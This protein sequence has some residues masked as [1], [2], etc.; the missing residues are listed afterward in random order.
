MGFRSRGGLSPAI[1][2][3]LVAGSLLVILVLSVLA[4]SSGG[5]PSLASRTQQVASQLRCPICQGESVYDSPSSLATAMRS[6]IRRQLAAG[7]S[8]NQVKSYFVSRYGAWIL[9]APPDSGIGRLAWLAPP[10]AVLGGLVSLAF[11]LRRW[12]RAPA[13]AASEDPAAIEDVTALRQE[14]D[15]RLDDGLVDP[16]TYQ[17]ERGRLRSLE[18]QLAT[19]V[20]PNPRSRRGARL[21]VIAMCGAAVVIAASISLAVQN[22]GTGP[23]T[24]T[25]GSGA[26]AQA[27]STRQVKLPVALVR[28]VGEVEAHPHRA[29]AWL[30][31]A[32]ALLGRRQYLQAAAAYREALKLKPSSPPAMVGLAFVDILQGHDHVA[33]A[34]LRPVAKNAPASARVWM[35][36]GLALGHQR[37]TMRAALVDLERASSLKP[38]QAIALELRYW[39]GQLRQG[40]L[41]P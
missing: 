35:L 34:L 40:S 20:S 26:P 21:Q 2:A 7:R 4:G 25:I 31:L 41:I 11:A 5:T 32:A 22:R 3:A 8:V 6:I 19:P 17:E 38:S 23:I 9:L 18:E 29:S 33:L 15:L 39:I 28:P 12:R 37:A 24:G 16:V 1:A 13:R 36:E 27:S 30:D 14:L 10:L